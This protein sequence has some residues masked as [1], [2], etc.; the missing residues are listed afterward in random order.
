MKTAGTKIVKNF[1]FNLESVELLEKMAKMFNKSQSAIIREL[2]YEKAKE[3]GIT[4][5]KPELDQ[6]SP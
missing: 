6:A 2:I 3:L 5:E 1:S 4:A